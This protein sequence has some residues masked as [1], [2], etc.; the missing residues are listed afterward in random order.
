MLIA[1]AERAFLGRLDGGCR[2]PLG[3]V[4]QLAGRQFSFKGFVADIEG[5]Q[6]ITAEAAGPEEEALP[7]ALQVAEGLLKKGGEIILKEIRKNGC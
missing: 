7:L 2:V 5:K 1:R 6:L 4:S 3:C